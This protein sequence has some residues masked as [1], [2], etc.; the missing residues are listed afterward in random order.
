MRNPTKARIATLA[1]LLAATS[2]GGMSTPAPLK[3][4]TGCSLE[5]DAKPSARG[6]IFGAAGCYDCG[7][8]DPFGIIQCFE[9]I[10]GTIA[11]C[12]PAP[13]AN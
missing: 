7:Y 13:Y 2:L 3:N 12:Q 10:D 6:C 1:L 4:A 5:E 8:S 9:N 11:Y